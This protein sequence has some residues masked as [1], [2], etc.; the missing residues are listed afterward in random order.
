MKLAGPVP[1]TSVYF[2]PPGLGAHE[3]SGAGAH[4]AGHMHLL[5]YVWVAWQILEDMF[6]YVCMCSHTF[7]Y[8]CVQTCTFADICVYLHIFAL[9][10]YLCMYISGRICIYI[11]VFGCI[12]AYMCMHVDT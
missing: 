9:F 4:M 6:V 1:R 10:V 3:I 5:P 8:I 11:F 7:V 12:F 2:W